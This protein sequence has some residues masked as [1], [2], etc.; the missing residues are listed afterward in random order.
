MKSTVRLAEIEARQKRWCDAIAPWFKTDH[1]LWLVADALRRVDEYLLIQ[2]NDQLQRPF[3]STREAHAHVE[4]HTHLCD[5]SALWVL[6]AYELVR[7]LDE[8]I[9]GNS[10]KPSSSVVK[11]IKRRFERVRM[12]LAKLEK[13]KKASA[14]SDTGRAWPAFHPQ[15]GVRWLLGQET[16]SRMSLSTALLEA[17]ALTAPSRPAK[18]RPNGS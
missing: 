12:P 3:P 7:V 15:E 9:N 14:P 10:N 17:L 11:Q 4:R 1:Q 8:R 13:A 6:G 16:V 2:E 5:V 18:R